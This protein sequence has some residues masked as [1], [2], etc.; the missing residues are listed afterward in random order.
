LARKERFLTVGSW[1]SGEREGFRV[2]GLKKW[3]MI[4]RNTGRRAMAFTEEV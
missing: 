3:V 4:V 2:L 1:K